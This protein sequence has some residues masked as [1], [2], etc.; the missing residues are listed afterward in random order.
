MPNP[1]CFIKEVKEALPDAKYNGSAVFCEM[2]SFCPTEIFNGKSYDG[3]LPSQKD[4]FNGSCS[5][6]CSLNPP[7]RFLL[8]LLS[9]TSL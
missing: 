8:D 5:S 4:F 7:Y 1:K 3:F 2:Q 9:D 6:P